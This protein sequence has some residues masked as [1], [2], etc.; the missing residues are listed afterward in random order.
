MDFKNGL[1]VEICK[2]EGGS[3]EIQNKEPWHYVKSRNNYWVRV[4]D[5]SAVAIVLQD[6]W[7]GPE[8]PQCIGLVSGLLLELQQTYLLLRDCE[9]YL[10]Y[11]NFM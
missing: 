11:L 1:K 10:T 9:L 3:W 6:T 7:Q 4:F 5:D 2:E 8:S